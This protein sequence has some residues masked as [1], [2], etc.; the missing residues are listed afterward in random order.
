MEYRRFEGM[1]IWE[2]SWCRRT[3]SV[4]THGNMLLK[5]EGLV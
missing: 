4:R 2:V 3:L 5:D 1:A